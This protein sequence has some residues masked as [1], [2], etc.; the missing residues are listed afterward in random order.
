MFIVEGKRW[1]TRPVLLAY[2]GLLAVISVAGWS[3]QLVRARRHRRYDPPAQP[4][5]AERNAQIGSTVSEPISQSPGP[6]GQGS[7]FAQMM[8]AADQRLPTFSV[9]ARR[10]FFH[11]LAVVMFVP[12]I[13][14]DVCPPLLLPHRDQADNQPA[15]THLS[16]SVA[17]AFFNFAEYVRYFAL[18][19][20]GVSVHLF[21]NE[22]LDSKDS[23][24]AIL[25]HFYLLA[26]CASPL[27]LE[28][29]RDALAYIGV[30]G[31]GIGDAL[32]RHIY[33][34]RKNKLIP[35]VDYWETVWEN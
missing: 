10:K 28:G 35:G 20:F 4:S 9:N 13:A 26:G 32:V 21:L 30:L 15:F 23:G 14:V 2:W 1:W 8:D 11:A 27:W 24:T 34:D 22:F 16:F 29:H 17:F 31:L 6:G 33:N 18:W 7:G 19:P 12:G 25:S 5:R 3:R